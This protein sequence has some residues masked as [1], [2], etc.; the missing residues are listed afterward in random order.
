MFFLCC[1]SNC[2][3]MFSGY[4]FSALVKNITH[5][6]LSK[7]G[8]LSPVQGNRPWRESGR[9]TGDTYG[10]T[11]I[12]LTLVTGSGMD[13]WHKLLRKPGFGLLSHRNLFSFTKRME[14]YIW[15]NIWSNLTLCMGL[16]C[17]LEGWLFL[18]SHLKCPLDF[19]FN[20]SQALR[21]VSKTSTQFPNSFLL[22]W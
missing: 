20:T 3:L 9:T 21:Q 17:F 1:V 7:S 5:C 10:V 12:P 15:S 11:S 13:L 6:P 2:S 4:F 16:G 19:H 18:T 8:N 22:D 14:V